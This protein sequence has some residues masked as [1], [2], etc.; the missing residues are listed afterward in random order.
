MMSSIKARRFPGLVDVA[1]RTSPDGF[2]GPASKIVAERRTNVPADHPDRKA[3][4]R[5]D[6]SWPVRDRRW[7][8]LRSVHVL[9]S[10]SNRCSCPISANASS[11]D[12]VNPCGQIRI[13]GTK[14]EADHLV[15]LH[16]VIEVAAPPIEQTVCLRRSNFA[17]VLIHASNDG[18]ELT[19][20]PVKD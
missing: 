20:D 17:K 4:N 5:A 19:G 15:V 18:I 2:A 9:A 11:G 6:S 14:L 7:A 13:L 10:G 8:P 12:G 16:G 1:N 3:E